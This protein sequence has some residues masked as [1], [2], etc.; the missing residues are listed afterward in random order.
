MIVHNKGVAIF[1]NL[2]KGEVIM[3][4]SQSQLD[5]IAEAF[6]H[7]FTDNKRELGDRLREEYEY[8]YDQVFSETLE[9]E[10]F[11]TPQANYMNVNHYAEV[12]SRISMEDWATLVEDSDMVNDK[13]AYDAFINDDDEVFYTIMNNLDQTTVNF[14]IEEELSEWIEAH[15][16]EAYLSEE[17]EIYYDPTEFE[18]VIRQ[19]ND[20]IVHEKVKEQ[21]LEEGFP[22]DVTPDDV[23][24]V[25]YDA[26]LEKTFDDLAV[27]HIDNVNQNYNSVDDYLKTQFYTDIV[28]NDRN[29]N[30]EV[31]LTTD[32]E[33]FNE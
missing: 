23:D 20:E 29:Y 5:K 21:L 6:N 22:E 16:T 2:G 28:S 9:N 14:I 30:F 18:E 24:F 25:I 31:E 13:D 11:P 4:L 10:G 1:I 32:P 33:D 3:A 27:E 19:N 15:P 17:M 12:E 26:R 7:Q 8:E